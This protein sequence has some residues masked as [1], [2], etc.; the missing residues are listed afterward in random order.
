MSVSRQSSAVG[1][2][3]RP[4]ERVDAVRRP[5]DRGHVEVGQ[6]L[7][8]EGAAGLAALEDLRE[9]HVEATGLGERAEYDVRVV[10]A[11]AALELL[12]HVLDLCAQ[13]RDLSI[14]VLADLGYVLLSSRRISSV[15]PET[16]LAQVLK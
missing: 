9:R 11:E 13:A 7:V 8:A 2:V 1:V 14:E 6:G 10:G 15:K 12:L 16:S 5:E 3:R 4:L